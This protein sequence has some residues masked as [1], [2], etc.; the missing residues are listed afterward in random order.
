M[1][2]VSDRDVERAVRR[3]NRRIEG[4]VVAAATRCLEPAEDWAWEPARDEHR[5]PLPA[6][7][8]VDPSAASS[9]RH[10]LIFLHGFNDEPHHW[11]ELSELLVRGVP[12][13]CDVVLPTAPTRAFAVKTPGSGGDLGGV[14]ISP[15][16]ASSVRSAR[17]WFEPRMNHA[18]GRGY[19]GM[20][21]SGAPADRWTCAGIEPAV[22]WMGDVVESVRRRGAAPGSVILAGF[23]QGAGLAMAV[24]ASERAWE[25]DALGGVICLRG[26]LPVR[27]RRTPDEE[28]RAS[29]DRRDASRAALAAA[30][31]GA[32]VGVPTM[33]APRPPPALLCQG[34]RDAVA[35][36]EWA[37]AAAEQLR[38]QRRRA[39]VGREGSRVELVEYAERGHELGPEDLWRARWWIRSRLERAGRVEGEEG[40]GPR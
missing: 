14:G 22:R 27:M 2:A 9:S 13:G 7:A 15:P 10:T 34:G 17:A 11:S 28:E 40:G 1:G 8:A 26:Y 29:D 30:E 16:A 12:G 20:N 38:A 21:P 31:R 3:V 32:D 18:R 33:R 24:A 4:A 6:D 23:S 39:G 25:C 5:R 19:H 35:P 37:R 36:P